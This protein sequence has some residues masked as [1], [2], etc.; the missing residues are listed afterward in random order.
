MLAGH[1]PQGTSARNYE[2]LPQKYLKDA[3]SEVDV[4]FEELTKHTRVRLRY[5]RR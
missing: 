5:T 4:F 2:Y 3:I 1:G